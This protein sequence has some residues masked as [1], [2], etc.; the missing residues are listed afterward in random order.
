MAVGKQFLVDDGDNEIVEEVSTT[1]G[2]GMD[3]SRENS[4][5]CD[6]NVSSEATSDCEDCCEETIHSGSQDDD[7]TIGRNGNIVC[8]QEI[9][10]MDQKRQAVMNEFHQ[11]MQRLRKYVNENENSVEP[12]KQSQ[13]RG[14]PRP[15]AVRNP[16][17]L[18]GTKVDRFEAKTNIAKA[19]NVLNE[20]FANSHLRRQANVKVTFHELQQELHERMQSK[21]R[22]GL[23]QRNKDEEIASLKHKCNDMSARIDFLNKTVTVADCEMMKIHKTGQEKY[24]WIEKEL[25]STKAKLR[26]A[27]AKNLILNEELRK[28]TLEQEG[29]LVEEWRKRCMKQEGRLEEMSFNVADL[30]SQLRFC[31]AENELLA[32]KLQA[33]KDGASTEMNRKIESLE[34]EIGLLQLGVADADDES[35]DDD[36]AW[37]FLQSESVQQ[38]LE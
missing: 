19:K 22:P 29:R 23:K 25:I 10:E 9:E 16:T 38:M 17:K 30:R 20:F 14:I 32:A 6:S 8:H 12:E 1:S 33:A 7:Q 34:A 18:S 4:S 36:S 24:R 31:H 26:S 15:E 2:K 5:S 27:D 35:E 11:S 3:D 28:R 13:A 37:E 21:G